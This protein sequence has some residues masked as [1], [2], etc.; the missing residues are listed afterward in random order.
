[1]TVGR[2]RAFSALQRWRKSHPVGLFLTGC[3]VVAVLLV[4]LAFVVLQG[5]Q[6]GWSALHHY[7]FE[8]SDAYLLWNTVRL[9]IAVTLAC[10]FIGVGA[11]L[12]TERLNIPGRRLFAVLVV[13]PLAIPDFVVGYAW[14]SLSPSIYGYPA[15]VLV[16]TLSLYPLVYL[17]VAATLRRADP[18]LDEVARSLGCSRFRRFSRVIVPQVRIAVL[19]GCLIVSLAL[20]AEYGAFEILRFQT[21]TTEIF[22]EIDVA[23]PSVASALSL[24]LVLLG[25]LVLIGELFASGRRR[26]ARVGPGAARPNERHDPGPWKIVAI[27]GMVVLS[28]LGLGVPVAT[29]VY[30]LIVGGS[31]TVPTASIVAALGYTVLYSGLA[32]VSATI[33]AIPIALLV[34]RHR[35]R[36]TIILERCA[37]ISQSL[38]GVVIALALV[39]FATRYFFSF[40]ESSEELVLSYVVLF[41]PFALVGVRA[42]V[43]QAP[44]GLEE[45]ARSLGC[46]PIK[47]WRKVTLPLVAPGIGAAFSLVFLSAV[48][49]LTATLLLRPTGVETLATQFW[50]YEANLSY[51]AAAPY[52]ALIVAIAAVPTFVLSR[53]FDRRTNTRRGNR[54]VAGLDVAR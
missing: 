1:M 20:F 50:V 12:C 16:M 42:A 53:W 51:G 10:A 22:T 15:A 45:I 25:V 46:S 29:L 4:P 31:T 26:V 41:F 34:V 13:L 18:G 44:T 17:P 40:Y 52:A 43:A 3:V 19:G 24:V 14:S 9:M 8:E 23:Q 49:E 54:E 11:A 35:G 30:W 36:L 21:F 33:L 28:A 7:I 47:A 38:P 5:E 2:R 39:F 37:F 32:A 6:V 27:V 48:T